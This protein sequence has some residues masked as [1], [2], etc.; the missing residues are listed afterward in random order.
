MERYQG[1]I[2]QMGQ[3]SGAMDMAAL[4]G[5]PTIYIEHKTSK[6]VDRMQKW[7]KSVPW[8][9]RA[10][11][12][13]PPSFL[14]RCIETFESLPETK[15][16]KLKRLDP[17][18]DRLAKQYYAYNNIISLEPET[19]RKDLV[20]HWNSFPAEGSQELADIEQKLAS[21]RN[22]NSEYSPT[23]LENIEKSLGG[24]CEEY[25][26]SSALIPSANKGGAYE[27]K[28]VTRLSEMLPHLNQS[29]WKSGT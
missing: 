4:I 26:K 29:L 2:V 3:K 18:I 15:G 22:A 9:Q 25:S 21:L 13:T 8:Y 1:K 23:D 7:T 28:R 14:G 24:L 10:L 5:M 16:I 17:K 19:I 20:E 27:Y 6:A 11:M 12:E